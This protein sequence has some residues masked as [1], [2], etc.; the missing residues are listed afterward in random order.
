MGDDTLRGA[1]AVPL[2]RPLSE[3]RPRKEEGA[4][5][6]DGDGSESWSRGVQVLSVL[7]YGASA[8]S[9]APF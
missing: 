2:R 4:A 8:L 6:L 5:S 7:Q 9:G 3:V 1:I